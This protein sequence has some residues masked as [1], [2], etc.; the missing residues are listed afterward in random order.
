MC[1]GIRKPEVHSTSHVFSYL[2]TYTL[3]CSSNCLHS[4]TRTFQILFICTALIS[5]TNTP[6]LWT[7][8][9]SSLWN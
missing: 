2:S 3:F 9:I 4:N 5:L 8:I 1:V 7:R 6:I